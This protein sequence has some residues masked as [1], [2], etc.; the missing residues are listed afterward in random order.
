MKKINI[1]VVGLGNV[2]SYFV[3]TVL[4]NK[5]NIAR[6]TG[7]I[8]VIKY[9]S[10]K[11]YLKKRTFN[12][13]KFIWKKN[14]LKVLSNDVDVV[15]EL[16]G[17]SSGIAKKLIFAALKN[18][19][20]VITANKSLMSKYGDELAIIAEKN[21]VN[22]E[23]EAA[24]AG[25][26]PIIR[27]LKDGLISNQINKIYGILNGTTNYILSSMEENKKTFSEVLEKAKKL[28]F[29]E[30]N[31]I[32]D[33]NGTDAAAKIRIL[34]SIAYNKTISKNK[35]L[36]EGIQH[37]NLVDIKHSKALGY[38]IKLLAI[39][40]IKKN[41]LLERVHPCL[42][43]K[44][45]R[46]ANI[47]GVLNAI[48]ID[49]FPIGRSILQGEGAGPGPTTSSLIS[50][51]C[52]VLRGNVKY[53]FGVSYLNRKKID[54]FD[55]LNRNLSSYLRINVKDQPG[56]LS[57]ITKIFSKNKISIKNLIQAPDKKRKIASI[58]IITHENKEK[59]F[60]NLIKNLT[61]N[62]FVIK[63]PTFIR[64]EKI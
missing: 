38:K 59:N 23:Y 13:N 56:V 5:N 33:L 2:G 12:K 57:S 45:S 20:H 16:V 64:I 9:I 37:I 4:K 3:K 17:G 58:A 61:K 51:L 39:S 62:K 10:A 36:V 7:R 60:K 55:I 21:K 34:S 30:S 43:S 29:A 26:V 32:A 19:K 6:K 41:K 63:K 8:P 25:G 24:V 42:V 1:A 11:N 53:P 14:P 52:S 35:I 49:G 18:K 15:V 28:G 27:S 31:P 40:E 50:D 48:V 44:D 46:I 22:L 54:K 47:N